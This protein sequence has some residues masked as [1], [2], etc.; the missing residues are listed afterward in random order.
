V[1]LVARSSGVPL[2]L[3]AALVLGVDLTTKLLAVHDP[4]LF[5]DGLL[6]NPDMP[7]TLVRFTVCAV[8]ILV[9]AGM[10]RW[11]AARGIGSIPLVWLAAGLLVGGVLGNWSSG[12]IWPLGVPDFISR[13]D[14]MWNLADFAIGIG[15]MLFLASSIG[16][17]LRAYVRGRRCAR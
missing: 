7:H 16:Y 6:H 15:M 5:G 17:V 12:V 10:S 9:V 11:A 14:R 13:G 8:T 3:G 1:K 4:M 2:V